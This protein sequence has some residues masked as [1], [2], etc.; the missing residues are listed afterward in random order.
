MFPIA[1]ALP[2][3]LNKNL[4]SLNAN[5]VNVMKV[6]IV[7]S[8]NSHRSPIAEALLKKFRHDIHVDSAGVSPA[9][10]ISRGARAFLE[11]ENASSYLKNSPEGLNEKKLDEYDLIVAMESEHKEAVLRQCPSCEKRIVIWNIEDPYFL[12]SAYESKIFQ[13]I[14]SK[15]Q[16]L[17]SSLVT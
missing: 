9:D 11:R 14:K 3:G 1:L 5:Y 16:E 4:F 12:P 2:H 17:A 13:Q 10:F 8:G 7:C 6:L 15:V